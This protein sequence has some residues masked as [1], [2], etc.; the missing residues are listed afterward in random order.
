MLPEGHNHPPYDP[1]E[2]WT[3]L[4]NYREAL[5]KQLL[6]PAWD[7]ASVNW[8]RAVLARDDYVFKSGCVK[9]ERVERIIAEDVVWLAAH[10]TRAK[11]ATL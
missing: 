8:K 6:T 3:A 9:K 10:P 7:I 1:S 5:V 4:T 2:R 11:K